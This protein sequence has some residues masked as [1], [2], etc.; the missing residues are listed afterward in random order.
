M[1]IT[2]HAETFFLKS[3]GELW[4]ADQPLRIFWLARGT[5]S[6]SS[7]AGRGRRGRNRGR[8]SG[9]RQPLAEP[10]GSCVQY[11][12]NSACLLSCSTCIMA[13][14]RVTT[15]EPLEAAA[16]QTGL[17]KPAGGA[18][19]SPPSVAADLEAFKKEGNAKFNAGDYAGAS[20]AYSRCIDGC[21]SALQAGASSA[22]G[23][24]PPQ[25]ELKDMMAA[26]YCN[27]SMCRLKQQDPKGAAA[28]SSAALELRPDY[29]KALYRQ[30]VALHALGDSNGA[31]TSLRRLL[32]IDP[33]SAD[34]GRLLLQLKDS[35]L[36]Q[37]D[38]QQSSMLPSSL[39]DTALDPAAAEAKRVKALRDLGRMALDRQALQETLAK[40]GLLQRLAVFL[41]QQN[42]ARAAGSASEPAAAAAAAAAGVPAAAPAAVE[43]AGWELLASV[44]QYSALGDSASSSSSSDNSSSNAARE[45]LLLKINEPLV[46]PPHVRKCREAVRKVWASDDFL[47]SLR[48]LLRL[49]VADPPSDNFASLFAA[50]NPSS[51][52]SSSS[53]GDVRRWRGLSGVYLLRAFGYLKQSEAEAFEHDSAFLTCISSG[54]DC[55]EAPA[56]QLAALQAL[57][58]AADAR[59]RLGLKVKALALRQGIER[60]LE[61]ALSLLSAAADREGGDEAIERNVEFTVV[62]LFRLLGDKERAE[63]DQ[64]DMQR[65]ADQLLSPFLS[66]CSSKDASKQTETFAGL[67]ALLF[68]MTADRDSARD[69]ILQG[70]LLPYILSAATG[71]AA[72][73]AGLAGTRQQRQQQQAG[74]EVLLLCLDHLELRQKL[75]DE[76]GVEALLLL[77]QD[78]SRPRLHR[79]K[80]AVALARMCVH[81]KHTKTDVLDRINLPELLQELLQQQQQQKGSTADEEAFVFCVLELFF[82]LSLH[83]EFKTKLLETGQQQNG[84]GDLIAAIMDLGSRYC[85]TSSS[86]S[87]SSS[88]SS[89]S[90]SSSSGSSS[91]PRYLLCG[92]LCNLLKSRADKERR[93]KKDG[94]RGGI[95]LE[96]SQLQELE[97]FYEQLPAEAKPVPNGEIDAGDEAA[98]L[99]LRELLLQRGVCKLLAGLCMQKPLPSVN[100]L[101]A[102]GQAF[103]LLAKNEKARGRMVQEGALRALL[104]AIGALKG[105]PEEQRELQQAAAQ[106]CISV[107]PSLFAYHEAL[108]LVPAVLPL[109]T[110]GHELLQYEGALALTNLAAVSEDVRQR[111]FAAG[112]WGRLTELLFSDNDLLRAAGLEG[113][114]NLAGSPRVQQMIGERTENSCNNVQ[115]L[116]L[117]LAFCLETSN[118]RAQQAAAGALAT[119]LQHSAIARALPSYENYG[120]LFKALQEAAEEEGPLLDRLVACLFNIWA[121]PW[122]GEEE[123]KTKCKIEEEIKTH[124]HKL[125]GLA[126][127]LATQILAGKQ[128]QQQQQQQQQ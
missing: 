23:L 36:R 15:G 88:S 100:V 31:I 7:A 110:D 126:A 79:A 124:K 99:E 73:R 1:Q 108:D 107:N 78:S 12:F 74:A 6:A 81:S 55:S 24:L 92:G 76:E 85:R 18:P 41:K 125:N 26:A 109:L 104:R 128:Q 83:A 47:L 58:A 91:F 116:R 82:F 77:L 63:A 2:Q 27:R 121:E 4:G 37:Q 22:S 29:A 87:N 70:S 80:V 16:D 86:S 28:D 38:Q 8:A 51:S 111:A 56:L 11:A 122:E 13:S 118:P 9:P 52:S 94:L 69:F 105:M 106:L 95:D 30:A 25:E 5:S 40:E 96:P 65:L 21:G 20:A 14:L 39:L 35:L 120:N 3:G 103:F 127:D 45:K 61:A 112:A 89:S 119:L 32:R 66:H 53:N 50:A 71:E 75:L 59:R 93:P 117:L 42:A 102:A 44:V 123:Q 98:I 57:A 19:P 33:K 48:R 54:L 101:L 43:A 64:V 49:G 34:G 72:A 46:I 90:G 97:A 84:K 10:L 68:L 67:R 17:T 60:C 113:C 62:S 114:C 115:D